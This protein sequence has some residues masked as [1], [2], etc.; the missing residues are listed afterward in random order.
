VAAL[1]ASASASSACASASEAQAIT[2]SVG[3]GGTLGVLG[4]GTVSGTGTLLGVWDSARARRGKDA[5]YCWW[6]FPPSCA[7]R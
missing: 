1:K 6:G 4:C 3:P 5:D 7:G 2:R